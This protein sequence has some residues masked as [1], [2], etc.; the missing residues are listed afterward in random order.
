LESTASPHNIQPGKYFF[1]LTAD[2]IP[3]EDRK[4]IDKLLRE[5]GFPI[6]EENRLRLY[7]E[8]INAERGR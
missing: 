6:T 1:E 8:K 4:T 7:L 2:G 5:N 3:Q